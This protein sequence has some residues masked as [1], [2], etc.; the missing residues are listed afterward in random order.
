M[1]ERQTDSHAARSEVALQHSWAQRSIDCV[2]NGCMCALLRSRSDLHILLSSTRKN[3]LKQE[4]RTAKS[5]LADPAPVRLWWRQHDGQRLW[6]TG[7]ELR[8]PLTTPVVRR[9]SCSV[10]NSYGLTPSRTGSRINICTYLY[11]KHEYLHRRASAG[12]CDRGNGISDANFLIVFHSNCGSI[13]HSFW[14]P[15]D[16]RR[17]TDRRRQPSHIWPLTRA[18]N[19]LV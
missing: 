16:G 8:T 18:A 7:S 2:R 1:S 12:G 10:Y 6:T 11:L 13:L 9:R 5:R 17:M 14:W 4:Y 3:Q 15:R 19:K